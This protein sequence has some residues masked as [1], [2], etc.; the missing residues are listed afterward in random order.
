ML[1]ALEPSS[2]THISKFYT[3]DLRILPDSEAIKF[4]G[5]SKGLYLK[6]WKDFKTFLPEGDILETRYPTE[7]ELSGYFTHLRED[8]EW[9]STTLWTTFSKINT[10]CK[11]KYGHEIPYARVKSLLQ[12]YNT[13]IKTKAE[14]FSGKNIYI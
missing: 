14:T 12:A 7:D 6:A 8:N 10:I 5:Q 9:A 11:N 4:I 1:V 13:D 3:M 2:C